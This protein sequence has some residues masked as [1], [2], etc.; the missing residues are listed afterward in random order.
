[1]LVS[2]LEP[3]F[4]QSDQVPGILRI[5]VHRLKP[6]DGFTFVVLMVGYAVH[7]FLNEMLRDDTQPVAF[8]LT[9]S[10]NGSLLLIV[11]AVALEI[12]L[13]RTQRQSLG[14][15][16]VEEESVA[17]VHR[18][19]PGPGDQVEAV[20]ALWELSRSSPG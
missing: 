7:R 19:W 17:W 20:F 2:G 5:F 14:L 9:L 4:L 15:E 3:G 18:N 10:Q 8:G 16:T 11:I 13:T 12:W 1:M 6:H